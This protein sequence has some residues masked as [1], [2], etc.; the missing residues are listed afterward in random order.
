M[1]SNLP[2]R[3]G[4]NTRAKNA[5]GGGEDR[6]KPRPSP[7]RPRKP[8]R[9]LAWNLLKRRGLTSQSLAKLKNQEYRCERRKRPTPSQDRHRQN[10]PH[11]LAP[12]VGIHNPALQISDHASDSW[13]MLERH[14]RRDTGK[15]KVPIDHHRFDNE[16]SHNNH[17]P[18]ETMGQD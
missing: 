7:I 1:E 13:R 6:T 16:S 9:S 14:R 17:A 15:V 8:R 18:P 5:L 2:S 11:Q 3:T 10:P 4:V 12:S